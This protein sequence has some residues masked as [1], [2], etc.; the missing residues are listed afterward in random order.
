[1]WTVQGCG[2]DGL[3]AAD[4]ADLKNDLLVS[5][6]IRAARP[7]CEVWFVDAHFDCMTLIGRERSVWRIEAKTI[8]AAQF[9]GDARERGSELGRVVR[10]VQA[11]A[12]FVGESVKISI[13][14][15]V[16]GFG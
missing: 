2:I 15:V 9:L 7:H 11:S 10:R 8:L 3:L 16:V 5:S 1:M 4:W 13:G 6:E 14:A 12:G